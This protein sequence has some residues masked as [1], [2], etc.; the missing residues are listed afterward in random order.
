MA[1]KTIFIAHPI[2]DNPEEN[3]K[4]VLEICRQIHTADVIPL[5]PSLAWRMYLSRVDGQDKVMI[6]AGIEE[7]FRRGMIDE[8]WFYGDKPSSGMLKELQLARD[9][10]VRIVAKT[11]EVYDLLM[12]DVVKWKTRNVH[13]DEVHYEP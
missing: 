13:F 3:T 10:R 7:Y 4:K 6:M 12:E 2:S 5:F 9:H 1:K 11:K 8:I